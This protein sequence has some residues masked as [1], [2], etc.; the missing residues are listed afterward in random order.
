V[1][2]LFRGL[3]GTPLAAG[4]TGIVTLY[5]VVALTAPWLTPQSPLAQDLLAA[6]APPSPTHPF[7]TDSLGRDL[8]SRIIAGAR[9]DI[10]ITCAG[11]GIAAALAVPLG[12]TA[13]YFGGGID[14]VISAATDSALTFPT[15]VLA[16]VLVSLVGSGLGTVIAAV[17]VTAAPAL[18]RMVRATVLPLISTEFVDAARAAGAGPVWIAFRHLLPNAV[19]QATIYTTLLAS[20]AI[21]TVTA[22]GFLGL[23][24][25]PPTPE[26][27][28]MLARSRTYLAAAPFV[29][30]FPGAAIGGL[31]LGLNLL[32]DALQDVF[33]PRG[34]LRQSVL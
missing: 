10:A 8:L 5:L 28:S 31:V 25:Q 30:V 2:R 34:S 12:L 18:T 4:G 6:L 29:M 9:V 13:G 27:G 15:L 16:I 21:L 23:G 3:C 33:D 7:G 1:R 11:T 32:G 19:G 20:Q 14:R 17:A 22:L 26:W 24:V